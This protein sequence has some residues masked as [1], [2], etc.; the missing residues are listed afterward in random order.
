L[1]PNI[2]QEVARRLARTEDQKRFIS[3]IEAAGLSVQ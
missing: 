2:R 1:I 3:G